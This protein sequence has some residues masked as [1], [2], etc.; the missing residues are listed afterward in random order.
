MSLLR[1]R[2]HELIP[3]LKK[4][5]C[6]RCHMQRMSEKRIERSDKLKL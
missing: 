5:I 1:K 3:R 4:T 6:G 2:K